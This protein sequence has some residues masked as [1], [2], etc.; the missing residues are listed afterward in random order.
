MSYCR[1]QNTLLDL[2]DCAEHLNDKTE[3]EITEENPRCEN[4]SEEEYAAR[5]DDLQEEMSGDELSPEE[6]RARKRLIALCKEI[7]EEFEDES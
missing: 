7:A 1:F 6:A 3:L 4:E 5:M 2:Q